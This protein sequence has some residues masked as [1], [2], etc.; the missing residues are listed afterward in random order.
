MYD[1]GWRNYMPDIGRWTQIDPLFNDL[2]FAHDINDVD[3]DDQE[4]VYMAIIND[5][6]IGGGIYNTDNLNPYGY[7]YNNPVSFDDPD[8]R[9]P[10][11][12]WGAVIGAAVD[13]G[14]QVAV[15]Y[16]EGKSGSDAWTDVSLTSIAVSAGAGALSGGISS[17]KQ[18]KNASTIAKIGVGMATDTGVS[19]ASQGIKNGK[20]TLKDTAIDVAAGRLA[21]GVG[22]A[23]EKKVLNS[24]T[25]KKMAAA[26]NA[27]KN[28]ARG[29]SNTIPKNKADVKGAVKKLEAYAG[30]RSAVSA[31]VS[32]GAAST[33]AAKLEEK[34]K[35]H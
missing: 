1:Y 30:K 24:S 21:T 17:L 11:C 35:K 25:G 19:V 4:E 2:K 16:A 7:G 29:K 12:I 34:K 13:Y 5:L 20:V 28:I 18:V 14:L 15:N 32:S 23:V 3:P 9:C 22:N 6:E 8:G 33:A 26:I 10:S 27:E 31:T